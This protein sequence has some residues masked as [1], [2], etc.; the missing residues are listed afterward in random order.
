[1]WW[2]EHFSTAKRH[3]FIYF[4]LF[5]YLFLFNI[6]G[7][8]QK[9]L[10][11]RAQ[12]KHKGK[13]SKKSS[14]SSS[15]SPRTPSPQSVLGS[16]LRWSKKYDVFVCHSSVDSDSEEAA[17]LVSFLEASPRGLRC[18]LQHRDACPGGATSTQLCQAVQD[19]HFWAL[20]LSP[21]F[22]ED[23]WCHYMMHQ[24]LAEGM[25]SSRIIPLLLNLSR[26][27]YPQE[28]K[29]FCCI[30]LSGDPDQGYRRIGDTVLLCE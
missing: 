11:I 10:N 28:L 1:M 4:I 7:W 9:V 30:D 6:L 5:I 27:Q 13:E 29:F 25:M 23:D 16:K 19:S 24:A 22:L 26:S 3:L 15:L 8:F 21:S 12:D 18:F 14:A 20:L 2:R 17:R